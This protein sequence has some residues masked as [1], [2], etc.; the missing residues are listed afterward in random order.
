VT[1]GGHGGESGLLFLDGYAGGFLVG[2]HDSFF[3][4]EPFTNDGAAVATAQHEAHG[5][6]HATHHNGTADERG[7]DDGEEHE[8]EVKDSHGWVFRWLEL[9]PVVSEA[10]RVIRPPLALQAHLEA[11]ALFIE[12]DVGHFLGI[13]AAII[14]LVL[15]VFGILHFDSPCLVGTP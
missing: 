7:D 12:H 5:E 11:R 8:Q 9:A 4:D 14:R 13:E 6:N 2:S 3:D 15:G 1:F 10:I